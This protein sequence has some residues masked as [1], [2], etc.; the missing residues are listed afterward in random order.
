LF[1]S[2]FSIAQE[3]PILLEGKID[4]YSIVM[5]IDTYDSVC[6]IKYFYLNQYKDIQLEGTI[7]DKGQIK[8]IT[9]DP[10]D[11]DVNKEEFDLKKTSTGYTGTWIS[12]NKRLP[13][14]LKETSLEK[15]KNQYEYLQGIKVLKQ[16]EPYNY[17]KTSNLI[18]ILD[19]SSI[20]GNVQVSWYRE[21]YSV[22]IMP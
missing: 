18:F 10:G 9:D 19:S 7:D 17:I 6:N 4:K 11:L 13:V 3:H 16:D 2:Y 12:G 1:T 5:E 15:Y 20:N 21:K 14:N 22:I 8:V